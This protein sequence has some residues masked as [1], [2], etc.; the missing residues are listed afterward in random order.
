MSEE[1]T[2]SLFGRRLL[3]LTGGSGDS[4]SSSTQPDSTRTLKTGFHDRVFVVLTIYLGTYADNYDGA[5]NFSSINK[6]VSFFQTTCIYC[7]HRLLHYI[8]LYSVHLRTLKGGASH[9]AW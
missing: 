4:Y 9:D 8:H 5:L 2:H 3:R 7:V 1:G 6:G